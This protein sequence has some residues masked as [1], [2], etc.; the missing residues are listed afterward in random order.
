MSDMADFTNDC[1]DDDTSLYGLGGSICCRCCGESNL[2]WGQLDT[3]KWVLVSQQ[4]VF[5]KC[6]INPLNVLPD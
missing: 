4:G 3:G 1:L 6:P 2:R 5:H